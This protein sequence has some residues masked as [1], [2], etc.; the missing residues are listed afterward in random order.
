ML[1]A[2][3]KVKADE[4]AVTNLLTS[5]S[6]AQ[7][8]KVLAEKD[9]NWNEY[10]LDEPRFSITFV[11]QD[12]KLELLFGEYNP[13]KTSCYLRVEGD[14]RLF[15]VAD[16]LKNSLDKSP[17]DLRDK[18]VLALAPA[19]VNRI[20]VAKGDQETELRREAAEK[21]LMT[22]PEQFAVKNTLVERALLA[23]TN[24]TA[25]D[26]IDNPKADGDPY[27]LEKPEES[28]SLVGEKRE[29]TLLVGKAVQKQGPPGSEPDRYARVKGQ[30]TVY[31]IGPRVLKAVTTDP[32]QLRDRTLLSFKSGDVEKLEV[33]LDGKKWSLV[34]TK[35][36]KWEMEQPEKKTLADV[37]PVTTILW[38]L[39]QMEWKSLTSPAPADISTLYLDKPR[40]VLSLFVK[41][42]ASPLIMK[43]GWPPDE[44]KA[45]KEEAAG[46]T[47]A[48]S[49][50][51]KSQPK[52]GK[53]A[54]GKEPAPEE[55]P[56]GPETMNVLVEPHDEK[57]MVFV[58]DGKFVQRLRADLEK[59]A[60]K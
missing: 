9:V 37:L 11:T 18:S 42:A 17:L 38:D 50:P 52:A 28:I 34:L 60:G 40:L 36:G 20:I 24:L 23:L 12:K 26:I 13:A 16:T 56:T 51:E 57:G 31:V 49:R 3:V 59:L 22:K 54:E 4:R 41:G 39:R 53:K 6:E 48:A 10:G 19:D 1:N 2:P 27:G 7:S 25:T 33:E 43:A 55:K 14:P 8:E 29:Q 45:P 5:A 47:P 46:G 30:D 32:N 58:A 21:W 44:K 35:D 15:L